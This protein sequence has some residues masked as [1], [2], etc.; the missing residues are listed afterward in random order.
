MRNVA[1]EAV[2]VTKA[3]TSGQVRTVVIRELTV[4]I[5]AGRMTLINGPSGCGKSTLLA[6]LSGLLCPDGGRVHCLGV[7][8]HTCSADEL[9]R[10]RLQHTGFVFQGFNLFP[11]LPALEQVMLPLKYQRIPPRESRQRAHEALDEVGLA[12]RA[13]ALP[14]ELSGGEKQRVALAR[15]LAKRPT[16][17]FADEPTSAL[18]S[19]NGQTVIELL[20][21]IAHQHHATVVCASHDPRLAAQ[22]DATLQ[23]EDGRL[24][25]SAAP[26][27]SAVVRELRP[28]LSP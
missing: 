16:L 10:F 26:K 25:A 27:T 14:A 23:I 4:E 1:I 21:R 7:D 18:D 8:L 13:Q 12:T 19:A 20:L 11:S 6:L 3:F 28:S 17:L 2:A 15:A 5:E 22:S 24:Q 9:E